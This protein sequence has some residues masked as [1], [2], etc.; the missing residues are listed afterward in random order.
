MKRRLTEAGIR[1]LRTDLPQEDVFHLPTPGAG[2]RL[3]REGRKTWFLLYYAPGTVKK[4][5][6]Y[7]GEHPSG[8]L[9]RARYLT[10]KEFEREYTIARGDLANGIDPQ[11]K[12]AQ[13]DPATAGSD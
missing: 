3:T 2:L 10:L 13:V 9:G 4:R 11:R 7:F 8:K 6:L 5:R 12:V 1:S